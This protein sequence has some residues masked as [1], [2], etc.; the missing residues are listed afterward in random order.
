MVDETPSRR[1]QA[2]S[3]IAAAGCRNISAPLRFMHEYY[4]VYYIAHASFF[5]GKQNTPAAH[6]GVGTNADVG[7]RQII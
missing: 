5:C 6:E 1:Y 7:I 3:L 2:K 4:I